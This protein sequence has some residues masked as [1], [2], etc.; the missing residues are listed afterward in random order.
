MLPH[1]VD[2]GPPRG[3][4]WSTT[5]SIV[6][7]HE[8]WHEHSEGHREECDRHFGQTE[9][10][11]QHG[12]NARDD[13]FQKHPAGDEQIYA[14]DRSPSAAAGIP[15]I[16]RVHEERL[17]VERVGVPSVTVLVLRSFQEADRREVPLVGRDP[18]AAEV[19]LVVRLVG[20]ADRRHGAR[21]KVPN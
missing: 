12:R 20:L 8:V 7:H 21:R 4:S 13:C 9:L 17:L 11:Q 1:G 2:H 18:E 19:V 10:H 14:R 3:R 5:R 16:D 15:R 6:I